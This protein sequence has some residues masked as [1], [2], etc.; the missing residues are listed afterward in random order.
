MN[1]TQFSSNTKYKLS[2]NEV[3]EQTLNKPAFGM[4]F[5]KTPSNE[6]LLKKIPFGKTAKGKNFGFAEIAQRKKSWIPGP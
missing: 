5:Y 2:V 6:M 4:S 3:V 1:R